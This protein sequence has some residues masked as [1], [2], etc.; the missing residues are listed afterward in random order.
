MTTVQCV[1]P[2]ASRCA[3]APD[4][5]RLASP[6]SGLRRVHLGEGS[7]D[8]SASVSGKMLSRLLKW[9][10]DAAVVSRAAS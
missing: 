8:G 7:R 3:L 2:Q 5:M 4:T 6:L 1:T 9:L 10:L